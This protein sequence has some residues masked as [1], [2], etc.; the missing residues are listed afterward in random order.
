M[1]ATAGDR[2][3]GVVHEAFAVPGPG[4]PLL[5]GLFCAGHEAVPAAKVFLWHR[6]V[7]TP[8]T[9]LKAPGGTRLG[10]ALDP[11]PITPLA[12]ILVNGDFNDTANAAAVAFKAFLQ[13]LSNSRATPI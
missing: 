10:L 12:A 1:P 8:H 11:E 5:S 4:C 13:G 7:G 2:D 9:F 3:A 6:P